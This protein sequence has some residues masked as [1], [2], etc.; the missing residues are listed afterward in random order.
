MWKIHSRVRLNLDHYV[1]RIADDLAGDY[2]FI[3]GNMSKI[4]QYFA[5][6][7]LNAHFLLIAK[8]Y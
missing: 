2:L 8:K 1:I 6:L 3:T 5:H 4:M 7:A